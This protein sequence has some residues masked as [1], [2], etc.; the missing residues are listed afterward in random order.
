[1][2]VHWQENGIVLTAI[3]VAITVAL[4]VSEQFIARRAQSPIIVTVEAATD[5]EDEDAVETLSAA[6]PL[7]G[8]PDE[9]TARARQSLAEAEPD[10]D[11]LHELARQAREFR[12]YELADELLARCLEL[13]PERVESLFLRARTQSDLGHPERAVELYESVL[14][15]SPNHQ[16]ATYNLGVLSRRAGDYPRAERFLTGAAA[17]SSGRIKS[18]ALHQ[19]GL[20][21]GATG[22]WDKA[23]QQLRESVNLRPDA[24]RVWLDLGN[25]EWKRNRPDEAYAAFDK[26]LALNRR[27]ADAHLAMGLL[28]QERGNRTTAGTHL[29]QAVKLDGDNAAYRKALARHLLAGGDASKARGALVWLSRN[30]DQEADRAYAQA[31][32]ALLDR[33]TGRMLQEIRRAESLQPGGYDDAIEQAAQVL[34]EQKRYADARGLLELLLARPSPTPQVLL[35]AARTAVQL[36]QMKEA[37]VLLRRSLKAQPENSE[38]WFQLGRV[39]SERGDIGAAIDAYRA[40]LARNP[41]A[42]NTRLNLAVL[43]ARNGNEH[44]ALLLYGQILKAH[45]RYTPALLNRARLHERAGRDAEAVADLEVAMR[46]A[47]ADSGIRDRLARLLL[48]RG[49]T[50]RAR[51]LLSDAVAEAPGDPEVRLLLAETELRAGR[52]ADALRELNRAASLAGDDALLWARLSQGYREA[53]DATASARAGLRARPQPGVSGATDP[54]H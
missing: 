2:K 54:S 40:S 19:L 20:T 36:G 51:V 1:M 46:V 8:S 14:A 15:R 27:L 49:E 43:H 37:E 5:A 21:Y 32:L 33:D 29:A 42:R 34:H 22:R 35:V 44:E 9:L 25:A 28:E 30:A 45:P 39:L 3:A 52:R 23:T 13:E 10:A 41:D 12:A 50:D 18:K 31:M 53:G 48:R 7:Y 4:V 17:I 6:V 24:A 47:P 26:A 11:L 38:A 16:K